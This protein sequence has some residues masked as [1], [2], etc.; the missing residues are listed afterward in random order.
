MHDQCDQPVGFLRRSATCVPV[1]S[2]TELYAD[3]MGVFWGF[4]N[5]G[6]FTSTN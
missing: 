1:S 3:V 4:Y 6:N 5:W 2:R